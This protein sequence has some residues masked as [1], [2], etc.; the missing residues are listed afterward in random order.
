MHSSI[1]NTITTGKG[2][3]SVNIINP[4]NTIKALIFNSNETRTLTINNK[5]YTILNNGS[6]GNELSYQTN[7]DKIHFFGDNFTITA[8]DSQ[9]DDISINGNYNNVNTSDNNDNVIINGNY[10]N[11]NGGAGTDSYVDLGTNNTITN[12]ETQKQIENWGTAGGSVSFNEGEIKVVQIADKIYTIEKMKNHDSS[13]P[14]L[15][16]SYDNSTGEIT[17]G[18]DSF[19]ITAATGQEDNIIL[20]GAFSQLF[21]GDNNDTVIIA[22]SSCGVDTGEGNDSVSVSRDHNTIDTGDGADSVSVSGDYNTVNTGEGDDSVNITDYAYSN[23]VNTGEGDDSVYIA[24]GTHGNTV[25][26]GEGND[27]VSVSGSFNTIDGGSG[28]NQYTDN[29]S[30]N[31][32][33]NFEPPEN[34][35]TSGGTVSFGKDESKTVQIGDKIYTITN[36]GDANN[37]LSW[38]IGYNNRIE[39]GGDHF[40][41][42]AADGQDDKLY[43]AG[44]HNEIYTGDGNDSIYST[45]GE[46][47]NYIDAGDGDDSILF[48]GD[49]S[50][51][52]TGNGNDYVDIFSSSNI[53]NTGEGNDTVSVNGSGNTVNTGLGSGDT[54][55]NLDK[56]NTVVQAFNT[57]ETKT[58]TI[59]GKTYTIKN[60]GAQGNELSYELIDSAS[61]GKTIFTGDD[62]IITAADGQDDNIG[63]NGNNNTINPGDGNDSV[64][65]IGGSGNTINKG[66]NTTAIKSILS[67]TS[68]TTL[69]LT[70][71][72]GHIIIALV[73]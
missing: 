32:F 62:F 17:F 8:A 36:N 50:T 25:N 28:Y 2:N 43:I 34:W 65:I 21:T 46:R 38:S 52:E 53:V 63:V 6:Q 35:G 10:N 13:S 14:E 60:V 19:R 11:V 48:S 57:N 58:L 55:T 12:F 31:T 4:N 56:Y 61:T 70:L 47:W 27:S 1:R 39:F 33:I 51:I 3:D 40:T 16:W 67:K 7:G 26:T 29:G 44:S 59:D 15:T 18:G 69:P 41:I 49:H 5:T 72:L 30:N 24:G 64:D 9:I 37:T 71:S 45:T 54:I 22:G 20:N 68:K 73:K 23:T 42:T 66:E